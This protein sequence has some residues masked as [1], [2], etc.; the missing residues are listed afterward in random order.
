MTSTSHNDNQR[1]TSSFSKAWGIFAQAQEAAQ[2][3]AVAAADDLKSAEREEIRRT[4]AAPSREE[5]VNCRTS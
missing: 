3:S 1:N 4:D 2:P 5:P